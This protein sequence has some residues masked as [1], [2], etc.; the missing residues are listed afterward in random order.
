MIGSSR[1]GSSCS[2]VVVAEA[3]RR[4]GPPTC[5]PPTAPFRIQVVDEE[6]G[7]GVPLVELRTVNQIRYV[8]DSNGIAAVRRA[9]PVR[10]ARCSSSSRATATRPPR[11][12]S[13]TAAQAFEVTEGGSARIE[14]QRRSTSPSGS[15]ASPAPGSIATAP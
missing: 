15:T 10:H 2:A 12:T 11:T 9:G 8:T 13:D 7:R 14:I 1:T 5:R 3:P 4:P 6:T